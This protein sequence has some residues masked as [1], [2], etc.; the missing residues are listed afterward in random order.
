MGY[1]VP[2]N[3]VFVSRFGAKEILPQELRHREGFSAQPPR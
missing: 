1:S 2:A 3:R